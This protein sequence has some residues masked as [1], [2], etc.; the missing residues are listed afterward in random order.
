MNIRP[1]A[2]YQ[3]GHRCE[4]VVWAPNARVMS[5]KIVTGAVRSY[6]LEKQDRGYWKCTADDV[7]PGD[8][9]MIE[10]DGKIQRPDPASMYQPEGVHG[11]SEIIDHAEYVWE[12]DSWR[13]LDLEEMIIY[14][15]HPGTYTPEGTLRA[16]A[17][18]LDELKDLGINTIELMPLAQFPGERNWGY[19]G[20]YPYAV[21]NSYGNPGDLKYLVD[22]SHRRGMAVLLDVVYNHLGPEGN[23]HR[24]F[25]PYFTSKYSTPWGEAINFDDRYSDEVK[26]Y[27]IQNSLYWFEYYHIDGV[28]LDAVH[29]IYDMSA[30][31]FLRCLC[32]RTAD[33]SRRVKKK[34]YLIA[35]S[36]LNDTRLI[37][38]FETGGYG[39]D[40]QWSDDFHHALHTLLTGERHGYY[41]DFGTVEDLTNA[42]KNGFVYSG[43]FSKYRMRSHGNSSTSRPGRQFVICSQNH[44]Q[45]GNRMMGDR[46]SSLVSFEAQ[47]LAAGLTLLLPYV[48]L[49]FMGEEYGESNPFLYF[50][51]HSDPDLIE[52]VRKGRKEEFSAFRWKE[53]PPD[54]QSEETYF[55]SKLDHNK[56]DTG[57]HSDLL[58][59]Y[60]GVIS[61]RK[62]H[63]VLSR[64]RKDETEVFGFESQKI[65]VIKRE[66]SGRVTLLLCSFASVESTVYAIGVNGKWRLLLDS[67]A[68]EWGGPGSEIHET[69]NAG[70][71]LRIQPL[72]LLLF[73]NN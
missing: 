68:E 60:K 14:E 27:F 3:S 55:Q 49:L 15:L 47:K 39:V 69:V 5:V 37:E 23:Y 12:D 48:P 4:F 28:R 6:A 38:P 73:E 25:G 52:A 45:T 44:D 40:A 21:Q 2:W 72:S 64:L 19:D 34:H 67:A 32:E 30:K 20:V 33:F 29:A 54:P 35:E 17:G 18:R 24:D 7:R 26:E 70:D 41:L 63:P 13:G 31:H 9:Y 42:M 51:S 36:D 61:L 22:E 56:K 62:S 11:P 58:R 16:I 8:R 53:E 43:Q 57:Q 71:S 1:G 65:I 50:V 10:I 66:F 59:F 46:L